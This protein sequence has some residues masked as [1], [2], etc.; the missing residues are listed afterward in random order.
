MT[1]TGSACTAYTR[2][3]APSV[4][5][6]W[7]P[8]WAISHTGTNADM[9]SRVSERQDAAV[10]PAIGDERRAGQDHGEAAEARGDLLAHRLER[11]IAE[12]GHP[13]LEILPRLG[14]LLLSSPAHLLEGHDLAEALHRVDGV[15]VEVARHL[16]R[17]RPQAIDRRAA[18]HRGERG[19]G[20]E[21]QEHERPAASRRPRA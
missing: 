12:E 9:A 15:G 10:Q 18:E 8:T 4:S 21:R 17:A 20:E 14:V 13:R 3:V 2:R 1:G 7:R 11:Q 6:S 5:A 16:A 19:I